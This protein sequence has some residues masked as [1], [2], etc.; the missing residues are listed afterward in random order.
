MAESK[1]TNRSFSSLVTQQINE[2]EMVR[3]K[4]FQL[5]QQQ[6]QIKAK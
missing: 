5:E 2:M 3:Q 6:L 1:V 4:V